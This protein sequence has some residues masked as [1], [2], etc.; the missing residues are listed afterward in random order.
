MGRRR[1]EPAKPPAVT[2]AEARQ[3]KEEVKVDKQIAAREAARAR[4]KRGRAT[5][6]SG[7]EEGITTSLGG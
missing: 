7:D 3:E 5:L 1:R 2:K 4:K 6:I